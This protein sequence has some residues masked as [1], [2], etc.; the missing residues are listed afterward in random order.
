[1]VTGSFDECSNQLK[2]YL[3]KLKTS[4]YSIDRRASSFDGK[5]DREHV[6]RATDENGWE[7]QSFN[8]DN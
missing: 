8:H 4:A 2:L 1:M 7:N 6:V 5:G 3:E